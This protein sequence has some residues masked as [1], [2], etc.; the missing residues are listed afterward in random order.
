[1]P[2]L[3][4]RQRMDRDKLVAAV[5][6]LDGYR[7]HH[8][9][10]GVTLIEYGAG[11]RRWHDLCEVPFGRPA[12]RGRGGIEIELSL[13][14]HPDPAVEDWSRRTWE[15][16]AVNQYGPHVR[17]D[18]P[19]TVAARIEGVLAGV[20]AGEVRG[21]TCHLARL[22]VGPEWQSAG[23]G[24]QLL[25]AT[26]D[27]GIESGCVRV[28]VEALVGSRAEGFYLGRGYGIAGRL[29]RW[30]EERDFVVMEVALPLLAHEL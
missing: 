10:E 11:E 30:R 1:V 25:R 13:S 15:Q 18:E 19:F 4:I 2:H 29:S 22:I 9:F 17:P 14:R 24:T 23:V 16:Y 20:A 28:R 12:L 5:S 7:A 6:V 8:V 27:H 26:E 3:T 21:L